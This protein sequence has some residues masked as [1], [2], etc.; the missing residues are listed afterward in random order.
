MAKKS[1]KKN[2]V[3][4]VNKETGTTYIARANE[5]TPPVIKKFDKKI[6]AHADFKAKK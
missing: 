2:Y 1:R 4:Y 3:L 5:K 6:R